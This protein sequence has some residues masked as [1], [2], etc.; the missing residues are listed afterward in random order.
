MA[1]FFVTLSNNEIATQIATLLNAQNKLYAYHTTDTIMN[2]MANYFVEIN[3]DKVIGCTGLLIENR[4]LSKSFHTSVHPAYIRRGIATK[5][6]MTAINNCNTKY[7]YGTIRE[8]NVASIRLVSKLG[9]KII[10]KDWNRDHY[11]VTMAGT[12]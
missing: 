6:L 11:V 2:S 1:E 4:D 10:R 9:W 3:R 8:D 12:T 7:I 5:L